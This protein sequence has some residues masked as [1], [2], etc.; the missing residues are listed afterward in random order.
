M[1]KYNEYNECFCFTTHRRG[2]RPSAKPTAL[3]TAFLYLL[4]KYISRSDILFIL[5]TAQARVPYMNYQKSHVYFF[6]DYSWG[7]FFKAGI[8]RVYRVSRC[9]CPLYKANKQGDC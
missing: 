4:N 1:H 9:R 3:K 6:T 7:D 5:F 2:E 8:A